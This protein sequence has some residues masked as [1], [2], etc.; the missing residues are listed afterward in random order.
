MANM[1]YCRWHNTNMDVADCLEAFWDNKEMS[2]DEM[3][4]AKWMMERVCEFLYDNE[5]IEE[6]N[7][8]PLFEEFERLNEEY[9]LEQHK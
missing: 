9:G 8:A 2:K 4:S 6:Y 3:Y 7:L 1:S 5:V